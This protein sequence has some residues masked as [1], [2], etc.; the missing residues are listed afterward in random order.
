VWAKRFE[1]DGQLFMP[2]MKQLLLE[3]LHLDGRLWRTLWL[4]LSRPGF[5]TVEEHAGRF[6]PYISARK[7][8]LIVGAQMEARQHEVPLR[9]EPATA[10]E[11]PALPRAP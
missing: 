2:Y 1:R 9:L 4:L 10:P 3:R 11:R 5:L 6:G 7:L 8:F